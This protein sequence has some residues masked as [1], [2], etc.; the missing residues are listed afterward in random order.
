MGGLPHTGGV[1]ALASVRLPIRENRNEKEP[2]VRSSRSARSGRR[3]FAPALLALTLPLTACGAATAATAGTTPGPA[4]PAG[5]P[6]GTPTGTPA[7]TP[8]GTAAP[9]GVDIPDSAVGRQ[10]RWLL[11]AVTRAPLPAAELDGHFAKAFLDQIPADQINSLLAAVPD[12]SVT[13][14]TSVTGTSISARGTGGGGPVAIA[15]GVDAAGKIAGLHIVPDTPSAPAPASWRELDRRL[16]A[17]APRVSFLAAEVK[18]STCRPVHTVQAG[19]A[20]PLGSMFKLYVL[21]AVADRIRHGGLSWDTE[22]TITPRLK[23]LGSGRLR[24]R[25]DGSKVTVAEAARLM[26]SISDN[27]AADLLI[28]AAGR[29]A[30]EKQVRRWSGPAARDTPFLTTRELF[31]LKGEPDHPRWVRTYLSLRGE[32]RRAFLA[33]TIDPAPLTN[34]RAW[35]KPR[36]IDS[37]EWFASARGICRAYAGLARSPAPQLAAAMSANDGGLG[38]D[39]A[40]WPTVWYKGGSE[41]GVLTVSFLARSARGR[42]YLVTALTSDPGKAIDERAAVPELVALGK[43]AFALLRH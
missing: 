35:T 15:I 6:T 42:T 3:A 34:V 10:L 41:P 37:I 32:H 8:S 7:G 27:T 19:T 12:L 11:D 9:G 33:K 36:D 39:P 29:H 30:V 4:A 5:T 23:S 20:R 22:L 24:D 1:V 25:P 17:L 16:R 18:G 43:G 21:G 14:L 2:L 28:H 26:I 31:Q 40:A 38:L 13:E